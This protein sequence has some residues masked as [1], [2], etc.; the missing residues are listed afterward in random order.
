MIAVVAAIIGGLLTGLKT[1][2]LSPVIYLSKFKRD[3][4][5][6][7]FF[8]YCLALGYELEITNVY[9]DNLITI[10]AVILPSI[11][12]LDAGLKGESRSLFGY[13]L[14]VAIS[15]GW[16]VR[17]VFVIA[18]LLALLYHFSKDNPK[19][20]V[21]AVLVSISLLI[22]GLVFGKSTLNLLGGSST[23]V[24]FISAISILIV[25]LFW[26]KMA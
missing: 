18:V 17:E 8:V 2:L 7:L 3:I 11:L 15:I 19:R 10:F 6:I 22:A 24:V 4:F 25:L 16:F 12:L 5:L 26:R 9:D 23:Q 14:F 1:P 20:G 21:F 13:I